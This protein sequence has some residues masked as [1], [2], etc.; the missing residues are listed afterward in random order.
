[1]HKYEIAGETSQV[2]E[3][4]CKMRDPYALAQEYN[5]R[6]SESSVLSADHPIRWQEWG[7]Q[8]C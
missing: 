8:L 5:S 2:S 7:Y 6:P 4:Q 1:M 3:L